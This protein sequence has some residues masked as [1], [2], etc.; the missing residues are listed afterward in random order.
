MLDWLYVG[1]SGLWIAGLSL[2]L[3]ALGFALSF[4]SEEKQRLGKVLSR[5]GF[6]LVLDL[7][8]LL[9][10]AGLVGLAAVWWEKLL[11]G[12]LGVSF[13]ASNW[14]ERRSAAGTS[15]KSGVKEE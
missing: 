3:T 12:L 9:F 1:L 15:P 2:E 14:F 6:R 8:M 10:C 7:G 5:N 4:A 13:I 11:W